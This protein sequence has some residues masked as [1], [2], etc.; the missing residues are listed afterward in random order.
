MIKSFYKRLA[1]LF[2]AIALSFLTIACVPQT[3]LTYNNPVRVTEKGLYVHY[4]DVGQGDAILINL[5]DGKVMMIDTGDRDEKV[6]GSTIDFMKINNVKNIDYLV[7]T[8]PDSDHAG[9][10]KAIIENFTVHKAYLPSHYFEAS[11]FPY[12]EQAINLIDE[13]KIEKQT[14]KSYM[15]IKGEEYFIGFLSP[16]GFGI[17]T[18]GGVCTDAE[19]NNLSPIMY[20]EYN[21]VRFLF[22]GD[23]GKDQEKEVLNDY[24]VGIYKK[25]FGYYG[26]N[27]NL[28]G[29]NFLK[30]SHHGAND[31]TS[32]EFLSVIKPENA[33]ISV[34][35]N[36]SY[37]HPNTA[38]LNR[39]LESNQDCK[40]YRTDVSG[41][42][43][44]HVDLNGKSK[45]IT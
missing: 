40:I 44:V 36:N 23:A 10:A 30:V 4:L 25:A 28:D 9:G 15:L 6:T 19:T 33:M 2:F 34:S 27:V 5:P 35:G 12:Y 32:E 26:F 39:I 42:I 22:T 38:V 29:I 45:V 13:K 14:F 31:A 37:G 20:L 18:S 1:V 21:G 11:L 3:E 17:N 43:T 41:T 7:L 16:L 8:H 24:V